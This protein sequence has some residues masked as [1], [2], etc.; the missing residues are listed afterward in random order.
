MEPEYIDIAQPMLPILAFTLVMLVW[1]IGE[2]ISAKTKALVSMMLVASMIFLIGFSADLIPHDMIQ[3]SGLLGL[4][5]AVIGLIIVHLGTMM[6]IDDLKAQWRT[7]V[8]GSVTV[9]VVSLVL[10]FAGALLFDRNVAIAGA[11]AITGGTL[12]ILMVQGKAAAIDA[13]G[14]NLG[15]LS[16]ALLAVFP[17]LILNFKNFIG[18]LV[19]AGILKKEAL[20]VRGEYRAGNLKLYEEE[21]KEN[22]KTESEVILPSY[23]QTPYA[24][25]FLLGLTE[26]FARWL[27]G[28]T[29]GYVNTFVIALLLGIVLRHFKIVKPS[30]LSTTD[31]FGLLMISIMVIAFGPLA[32]INL[33]D[34]V[35]LIWP[36]L[37]YLVAG[38]LSIMGIAY[39]IGR[40]VGYSAA[41][42]IA[43]GLTALFGFPGTMVL[44]KEAAA[45]VGE[46]EEEIAVIEQNILPIMVTA[47]FSTITITSVIV[48]GIM[49][50]FL[51][52]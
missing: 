24:V 26:L 31:S 6:S 1:T 30:A 46:T 14:G 32:D 48:G 3:Q 47:G 4:G 18:F 29:N 51:V 40:Q 7:F 17:L 41:L 42:S 28:L 12:S 39:V 15:M 22:T 9:V 13:A 34:L 38:V 43:V 25:L 44:T 35:A 45:A 36:I 21:V 16:A 52:G 23:L 33:A 19:T 49:V 8:I 20:R 10:Y 2:F 50:G 5:Q 37:F 11:S 27:S